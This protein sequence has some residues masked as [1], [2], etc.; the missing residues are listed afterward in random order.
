LGRRLSEHLGTR[1]A[2]RS[3]AL[4]I[5]D[6][7]RRF[8]PVPVINDDDAG[9]ATLEREPIDVVISLGLLPIPESIRRRTS[10]GALLL[11]L[12]G[13]RDARRA[14]HRPIAFLEGNRSMTMGVRRAD[15]RGEPGPPLVEACVRSTGSARV[16]GVDDALLNVAPLLFARACLMPNDATPTAVPEPTPRHSARER[17]PVQRVTLGM[18]SLVVDRLCALVAS[19]QWNVGVVSD[20]IHRFLDDT[21]E[22]QIAWLPRATRGRFVADPFGL[23]S[24]ERGWLVES[25]D[26]ATRRGVIAAIDSAGHELVAG[27]VIEMET[28][29]SYPYLITC[30]SDIFCVPQVESGTGIRIFRAVSFPTQWEDAGVLVP[31]VIARDASVFEHDGRWWLA[32]TDAERGPFTHLHIWWADD[33]LGTWHAHEANPVKIDVRSARPA[34]T[35]FHHDGVLYRPAQDCS[36]SYG[37]A[38]AI[39]RVHEL[40][41]TLFREEVVRVVAPR[42]GP[43][44]HGF[45]T[46]SSVGDRTLVDGKAYS[47]TAAGAR[48]AF[49]ARMRRVVR[50][51]QLPPTAV[52]HLIQSG[53]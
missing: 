41:P 32:F 25:Y 37:G 27:S 44:R 36:T 24:D 48:T 28:H 47:F 3:R 6:P 13:H 40:T 29:A 12:A 8:E 38:V 7:R 19:P 22:P 11:E 17:R 33:L 35:P 18:Q 50:G 46:L 9:L 30:G 10:G 20:P 26:Y 14:V 45:H 31:D 5:V 23:P 34:G 53:D 16:Q 39:C 1:A 43:Y 52:N 21:Y 42:P 49:R 51:E 15:E 2:R 4:S